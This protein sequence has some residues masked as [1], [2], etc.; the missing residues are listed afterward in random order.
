MDQDKAPQ[1]SGEVISPDQARAFIDKVREVAP[2]TDQHVDPFGSYVTHFE[3]PDGYVSVYRPVLP[4]LTDDPEKMEIIDDAYRVVVREEEEPEDG[5]T[6]VR[7]RMYSVHESYDD[8]A[9]SESVRLYNNETREQALPGTE[10]SIH[11]AAAKVDDSRQVGALD[12]TP[13]RFE[14]VMKVLDGLHAEEGFSLKNLRK[15]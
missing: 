6:L 7:T 1:T 11:E 15:D 8:P 9:Y 5:T 4:D 3:L 12:F 10:P 14:E 13:T 2:L